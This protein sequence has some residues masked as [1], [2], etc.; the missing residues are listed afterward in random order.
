MG[1]IPEDAAHWDSGDWIEWHRSS[2]GVD[3]ND[4]PEAAVEPLARLAA[5]HVNL[6]RA[7]RGYYE[8]TGHHLPVYQQIA[9][10]H[11]A[12]HCD[13][14]LE[15]PDRV[16]RST[17]V[18]IL[19]IEPHGPGNT[20]DVDLT[21]PFATLIVVRIRDN[22][23]SEARMIQ[24]AALPESYDGHYPLSWKALPHKL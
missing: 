2:T 18:E 7:A 9:Y 4:T 23:K 22:F 6:T 5:L 19:W 21:R 12:I 17:G 20:V 13:L 10:T 11:A 1:Q 8:L 24:R 15:G 16:C 3:K 14:P